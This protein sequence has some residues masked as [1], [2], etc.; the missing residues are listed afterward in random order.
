MVQ[1]YVQARDG[2][3]LIQCI[4]PRLSWSRYAPLF[5]TMIQSL[6]FLP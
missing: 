2:Y 6:K 1:Y 3:Y 4:A 5:H